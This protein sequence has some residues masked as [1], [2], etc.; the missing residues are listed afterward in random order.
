MRPLIHCGVFPIIS[1]F[2]SPILF[3]KLHT[4]FT[5]NCKKEISQKKFEF[6][7]VDASGCTTGKG[8]G[9]NIRQH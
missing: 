9:L 5:P 3:F 8:V 1:D 6:R 4:T 7:L 2:F